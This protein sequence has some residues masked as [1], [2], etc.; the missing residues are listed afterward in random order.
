MSFFS[1]KNCNKDLCPG[2]ID[3]ADITKGMCERVCIQTKRVF[4]SCLSQEHLEDLSVTVCRV[5]PEC[6]DPVQPYTFISCR[7]STTHGK[8]RNLS[9]EPLPDRCHFFRVRA[10]VDVPLEVVFEDA[11][12]REFTGRTVITLPKDIILFFPEDSIIPTEVDSVVSAICISGSW[13]SCNNFLISVCVTLILKVVA[14][15]ELLVPTYGYCPIP[16]CEEFES[17]VCD[18]FFSLPIFPR[19]N[20]E[21]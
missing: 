11:T 5:M 6:P 20:F 18:Q 13:V 14:N 1:Y 19:Q 7:S 2:R 16:P 4:D 8:I 10:L 3:P 17:E 15:V 9:I 21:L 12:G